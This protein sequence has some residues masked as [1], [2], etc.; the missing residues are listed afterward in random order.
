MRIKKKFEL[1]YRASGEVYNV[2]P[3]SRSTL[4]A[5]E[6]S[7]SDYDYIVNLVQTFA[8]VKGHI[9]QNI[10]INNAKKCVVVKMPDYPLPGFMTTTGLPVVNLSVLPVT[11]VTDYSLTDMYSMF[12]YT[13][14]LKAYLSNKPFKKG[15]DINVANMYF[16]IF[17]KLFGKKSGLIGAYKDLIPN[18]KYLI[19]LYT[20]CSLMGIEDNSTL[21]RKISADLYMDPSNLKLDYDFRSTIEFIKAINSNDIIALSE[22]KFSSSIVNIAGTPFLP[23]FEDISR[24]FATILASDIPGNSQFSYFWARVNKVLFEKLKSFAYTELKRYA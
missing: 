17:M 5:F 21:R 15:H 13:I 19:H 23:V 22:Y 6:I 12:L 1:I 16:S 14:S 11:M 9:T 3:L 20:S 7:K 24:F 8:R 10:V 2:I 18:L 4:S